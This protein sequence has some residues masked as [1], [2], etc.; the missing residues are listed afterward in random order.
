MEAIFVFL[1]KEMVAMIVSL[2]NPLGIE[3]CS[4]AN[5]LFVL[6]EIHES[7]FRV[8][9]PAIKLKKQGRKLYIIYNSCYQTH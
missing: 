3:F 2:I 8:W 5:V 7:F 9:K 6:I 4:H 1:N